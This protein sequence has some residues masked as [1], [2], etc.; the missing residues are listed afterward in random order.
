MQLSGQLGA[1]SIDSTVTRTRVHT[2]RPTMTAVKRMSLTT[3]VL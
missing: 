3:T 2:P 1:V